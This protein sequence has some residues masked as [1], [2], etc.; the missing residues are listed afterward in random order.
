MLRHPGAPPPHDGTGLLTIG[1]LA[2]GTGLT[3][4][5]IRYRSDEGVLHPV[6]RSSGG[7][8]L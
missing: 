7:Y 1:E 3:V 8:R 4:R 5:T 6:T 2:R